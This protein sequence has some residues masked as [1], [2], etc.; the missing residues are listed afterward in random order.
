MNAKVDIPH[1]FDSENDVHSA[2][3]DTSLWMKAPNG[4]PSNL[5]E[6]QWL[7]VRTTEFKQ[8]FGDWEFNTAQASKVLDDNGEPLVCFHGSFNTFESF[9]SCTLSHNTGNDGHYGAGFYFSIEQAEA[10]TYG[11]KIYPVFININTPV[12]NNVKS[13]ELIAQSFGIE[14]K[15]QTVNK[16]WLADQISAKDKNAGKLAQLMAQGIGYERAWDEFLATGGRFNSSEIDLNSVGDVFEN[17][18]STLGA[19][20]LDFITAQFGDIPEHVKVYG[21]DHKPH[22][23]HLTDMGNCGQAFTN[24][25][26]SHGFNGV[27]AGSEIV[28]FEPNQIKSALSNNGLFSTDSNI[29]Q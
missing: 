8:W 16:Q 22:I 11:N 7:Q 27:L 24:I 12:F 9:A 4:Q 14:K 29:Y 20:D 2:Y 18:D 23:I 25:A 21:Y 26:K 6:A 28:A 3:F 15:F 10:E 5:T 19:Y 1:F 17:I 13:L